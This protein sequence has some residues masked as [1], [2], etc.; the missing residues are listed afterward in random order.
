MNP[1]SN[2]HSNRNPLTLSCPHPNF[3]AAVTEEIIPG[4]KFSRASY[5][6]GILTS[7]ITILGNIPHA[8]LNR[9]ALLAKSLSFSFPESL[10]HSVSG[11]FR[12]QIIKELELEKYGFKYLPRNPSSFTPTKVPPLLF[13]SLSLILILLQSLVLILSCLRCHTHSPNS[14]LHLILFSLVC[15][16]RWSSPRQ[17]SPPRQ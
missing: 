14:H 8:D 11:L 17:V 10:Q 16:D 7:A 6:A 12:P 15:S 1:N 5:L 13:L 3:S 9:I 2:P 4:F